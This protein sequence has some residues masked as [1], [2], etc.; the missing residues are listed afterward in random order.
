MSL[1][2]LIF[3]ANRPAFMGQKKPITFED[4]DLNRLPQ[5]LVAALMKLREETQPFRKVHRL[6]DAIEVFV[7]LHTVAVVADVF[8]VEEVEPEVQGMLAAGLRTPSLGVWWMFAREFAKRAYSDPER[9]PIAPGLDATTMKKGALFTRMEG[10]NN[11]ISFRNGYAHGS[12][13]EDEAC[14]ADIKRVLPQLFAAIHA[15]E[16]LMAMDW[17]WTDA[18]GQAHVAKGSQSVTSTALD[19]EPDRVYLQHGHRTVILHPLIVRMDDGRFF[20][21]NDLKKDA[22]NFLNYE[23]AL[24][25][26]DKDLASH[27]L[28]RFPIHDW[29]KQAPE[30]FTARVE[31]LT[32]WFKGRQDEIAELV[33]FCSG[34]ARELMTLWGGPG[35]GKS[36][37][38]ARLVQILQ[39][40][41]DVRRAE[42]GDR[43]PVGTEERPL[44]QKF[45]VLEYFIRRGEESSRTEFFLKNMCQRLDRMAKTNLPLGNTVEDLRRNFRERLQAVPQKL[46]SAQ[47]LVLFIDGLDEGAES[48]GFFESLPHELPDGVVLL[49]ASRDI[50]AV[51]YRVWDLLDRERKTELNLGGLKSSDVRA[52]LSEVVSKYEIRTEY[53]E[54]VTKRSEGN[55]LYLKLL[56]KGL[57]EKDFKLNA[58]DALPDG[59]AE[60]YRIALNRIHQASARSLDLLRVLAEGQ[61]DVTPEMMAQMLGLSLDEVKTELLGAA[62]ELL[63]ENDLTEDVEDYQ[64]FH[65][66]LREYLRSKYPQACADQQFRWFQFCLEDW[67]KTRPS[68][69]KL[70]NDPGLRY[71][72]AHLGDHAAS[73]FASL[74]QKEQLA[75]DPTPR[76]A[77]YR[78]LLGLCDDEAYRDESFRMLGSAAGIESLCRVLIRQLMDVVPETERPAIAA[79]LIVRFHQ[80]PESRYQKTLDRLDRAPSSNEI[81]RYAQAGQTPRD[82]VLLVVRGAIA[83]SSSLSLDNSLRSALETWLEEA[84]DPMLVRWTNATLNT[85][86]QNA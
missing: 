81:A 31:E 46:G 19:L 41:E 3:I 39:W 8:A 54:A 35:I 70:L 26:R 80:E 58:I 30:D 38:M 40:P 71:A 59:M 48:D 6:I 22:A 56:A 7:K 49:Y 24:H 25:H 18:A 12:T 50:P 55:P 52:L 42:L 27:L 47:R 67:K 63:H 83:G 78:E 32:E 28:E 65:E 44:P 74:K 43:M 45:H 77:L 16:A 79:R 17:I 57:Q 13:P 1:L 68:G 75:G 14:E 20:F 29:G 10:D 4:L 85:Q 69:E 60:L 11:W 72:F 33:K 53:I 21:Y 5:P 66:S 61:S 34:P 37:L 64:L 73:R 23:S 76:L 62:M 15:S 86:F 2:Q 82:R 9:T 51:R 36:A 84:D